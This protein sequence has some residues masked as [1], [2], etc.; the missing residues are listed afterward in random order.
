MERCEIL[1]PLNT[2]HLFCVHYVFIPKINKALVGFTDGWNSHPMSGCN[3]KSPFMFFEGVESL[4][5]RS[6]IAQD[7]LS[8]V[9]AAYGEEEINEFARPR[10]VNVP[11]VPNPLTVVDFEQLQAQYNPTEYQSDDHLFQEVLASVSRML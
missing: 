8:E 1:D 11:K 10:C 6:I 2:L 3:G 4:E 9:D 5:A 7:F